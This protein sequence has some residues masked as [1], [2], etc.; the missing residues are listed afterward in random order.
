MNKE[1]SKSCL[2]CNRAYDQS[3]SPLELPCKHSYCEDC[4]ITC[5]S[6]NKQLI[7][8]SENKPFDKELTI[9]ELN[10]PRFYKKMMMSLKQETPNNSYVCSK[11]EKKAI[12]F[13]C[14]FHKQ[15]LCNICVWDHADHKNSTR[16]Y[17]EEELL[18]DIQKVEAKLK[19]MSKI[20]DSLK[21]KLQNV[22]SK[23][24]FQ[25]QEI[26]DFFID[27][28]K[29]LINPFCYN[30]CD[31]NQGFPLGVH[32]IKP[33]EPIYKLFDESIILPQAPNRDY[34]INM[35]DGKKINFS[36][37]LFRAS[38]DG[39]G[40]EKFHQLCDEKGPTVTLVKSQKGFYFGGFNTI[41]WSS[42]FGEWKPAER[43]FLFSLT[44]KTKHDIYQNPQKAVYLS[45]DYGPFFGGGNDL[46]I[47]TNCNQNESSYSNF[48]HTYKSP[49][50]YKTN[51]SKNYLAGSYNFRVE[52]YEVFSITVL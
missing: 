50:Q 52:D 36:K 4:L 45:K 18:Q 13:V 14:D 48:G 26:K 12:E 47:S 8:F 21:G 6:E 49:Y 27:A 22:Q 28:N 5:Y 16:I 46:Y 29:F 43:S 2:K 34:I 42:G 41:S 39:F 51:E 19:E 10:I 11:H 32:Q 40:V 25:S 7:C 33:I 44:H 37:L 23:K 35:F 1:P 31:E 3:R 20:L 9:E 24:I 30:I 17:L 15:F 38:R